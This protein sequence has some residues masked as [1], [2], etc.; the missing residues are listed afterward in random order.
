MCIFGEFKIINIMAISNKKI[1]NPRY[2]YLKELQTQ[3]LKLNKYGIIDDFYN[4]SNKKFKKNL[5]KNHLKKN[6]NKKMNVIFD[7]LSS[8]KIIKNKLMLNNLFNKR[9]YI[10]YNLACENFNKKL[11]EIQLNNNFFNEE[12]KHWKQVYIW[13][14][15]FLK[16]RYIKAVYCQRKIQI[17]KLASFRNV[18]KKNLNKKKLNKKIYYKI[19]FFKYIKKKKFQNKNK[20]QEKKKKQ[21]IERLN[22]QQVWIKYLLK[23]ISKMKNGKVK[24]IIKRLKK[25][26]SKC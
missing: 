1:N 18:Y 12:N 17:V 20:K 16:K 22:K 11:I 4:I 13:P 15:Y 26:Q 8:N 10:D 21:I 5:I 23:K 9:D 2:F 19:K 14:F 24:L 6:K 3:Q 7:S 25:N